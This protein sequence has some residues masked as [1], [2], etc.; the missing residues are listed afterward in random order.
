[1][2]LLSNIFKT[3]VS[4]IGTAVDFVATEVVPVAQDVAKT[5]TTMI[6]AEYKKIRAKYESIDFELR[7]N[8]RFNDIGKI[9][10]DIAEYERKRRKDGKLNVYD[11]ADLDALKKRRDELSERVGA[12]QEVLA[13]K[14][15]SED[16]D[17]FEN[18]IISNGNTHILQ[19]HVGQTVFGKSC[20]TCQ[21][22][23]ILQWDRKK[24][25][26]ALAMKDFFWGCTGWYEKNENNE[27]NSHACKSTEPFRR[28][29]MSLFTRADRP[30]LIEFSDIE[31]SDFAK[32]AGPLRS[33]TSKL[34]GIVDEPNE[35]Y[36]CPVHK[37]PMVLKEHKNSNATLGLL[38]QYF[39]GCPRWNR[40]GTGCTQMVKLASPAQVAS[41]LERHYGKGAIL[42]Q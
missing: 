13:A 7:K 14:E 29:D 25:I 22:P 32:K 8:E 16:S 6:K 31:F 27:P 38:D 17:S 30:E 1:M 23:M 36:T 20:R 28:N 24:G 10:N 11:S 40:D 41:A 15:M 21:R 18:I 5:V 19:F 26:N 3:A 39:M 9:N 33:I 4:V 2:G 34:K 37:E 12:I 42:R 35:T